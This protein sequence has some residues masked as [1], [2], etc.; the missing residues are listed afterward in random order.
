MWV[1][2][3]HQA[4]LHTTFVDVCMHVHVS[5]QPASHQVLMRPAGSALG[6]NQT[7]ETAQSW[8]S[9]SCTPHPPDASCLPT[10]PT[11]HPSPPH[12]PSI[13]SISWRTMDG[14]AHTADLETDSVFV[15]ISSVSQIPLA[16]AWIRKS[17]TAA[18]DLPPWV[19]YSV[20]CFYNSSSGVE[21]CS[22]TA[23]RRRYTPRR[24]QGNIALDYGNRNTASVTYTYS[25]Y[26]KN[27][28]R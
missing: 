24:S 10:H 20:S 9:L 12:P 25:N 3:G 16:G 18:P 28:D 2:H 22:W 21:V 7:G 14:W 4:T 11:T 17:T 23:E 5:C 19:A 27:S 15:K 26:N 8:L 13:S 6:P 1:F